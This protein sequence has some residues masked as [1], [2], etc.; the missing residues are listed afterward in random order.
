MKQ[1]PGRRHATGSRG[2]TA[3][4]PLVTFTSD[5]GSG[6]PLVAAMKAVVLAGCPHATLVDVSHEVPRFDVFAGAFMLFAG[7]RHF[8]AGSVH[9]AVVDPGV[10]SSRRRLAIRAGGRYY[11]GPD[12]GLF[13]IVIDEVG[14]QQAVELAP[15]PGAAPT[16]EGRDVFAPA[17]AALAAGVPLESLG[18][19]TA[20]PKMLDDSVPRVLWI[21]GFGNLVTNLKPPVRP[22]RI[23]NHYITASATT[24]ADARP[25]EPFVYVGSMGYL[26]VGIRE[27]R[28][29]RVLGA[30]AGMKVD[31]L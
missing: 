30:R 31:L 8:G 14:M 25:N 26:E 11:V 15:N 16:F 12:N 2:T 28:A 18:H 23:H 24:Y 3:G 9:L 27:T 13:G 20:E 1:I 10:G 17:A 22:M 7:T 21:D 5:F 19:A 29:D 4:P 6:S